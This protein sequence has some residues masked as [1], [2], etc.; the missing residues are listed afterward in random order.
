[1]R[2]EGIP[3]GPVPADGEVQGP[4]ERAHKCLGVGLRIL[5]PEVLVR[6]VPLLLVD[7]LGQQGVKLEGLEADGE[8]DRGR[9]RAD[10]FE[11]LV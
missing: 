9:R 7:G 10:L 6:Q 1:M 3:H 5:V 11:G 8:G 2:L 4:E